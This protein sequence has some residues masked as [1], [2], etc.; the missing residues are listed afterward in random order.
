MKQEWVWG[1]AFEQGHAA[2]LLVRDNGS[3]YFFS[4]AG[5]A[6]PGIVFN[7]TDGWLSTHLYINGSISSIN[8]NDFLASGEVYT[9]SVNSQNQNEEKPDKYS[10]GIYIPITNDE[11]MAMYNEAMKIRENPNQY[12]LFKNN[13]NQTA[14]QILAAGGKDFASMDFDWFDT[15]PNAVY[16]NEKEEILQN[17]AMGWNY[18]SLENLLSGLL[19]DGDVRF[20][21]ICKLIS[22]AKAKGIKAME[23]CID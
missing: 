20:A 22:E 19:Y 3:G 7:G 17:M 13:C 21:S 15:R 4:Y 16:D 9:D 14:Q 8:V 18:G 11:G 23:G 2:V 10:H 1:G 12:Q 5:K 6:E